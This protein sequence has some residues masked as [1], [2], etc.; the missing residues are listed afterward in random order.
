MPNLQ[1]QVYTIMA[2]SALN[3]TLTAWNALLMGNVLPAKMVLCQ[4]HR[5][6]AQPAH[7]L[8]V[9]SVKP[10]K[11][12]VAAIRSSGI[13]SCTKVNVSFVLLKVALYANPWSNAPPVTS[14]VTCS[15]CST[16]NRFVDNGDCVKCDD[17]NC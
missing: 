1:A 7:L 5:N 4:M 17:T 3:V 16:F 12:V 6:Y 9:K 15:L 10:P 8:P 14:M 11:N 13:Y 2:V